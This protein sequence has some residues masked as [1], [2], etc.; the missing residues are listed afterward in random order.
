MENLI[1]KINWTDRTVS[2]KDV[3]TRKIDRE[4]NA[5][6]FRNVNASVL[7]NGAKDLSINPTDIQLAQDYLISALTDLK[8]EEVDEL[9]IEDY[10]TI[11]EKVSAIKNPPKESQA[12]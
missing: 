12:L 10:Q 7:E 3:Y 1:V 11:L 6:L 8:P 4:F 5:I 9:S 2:F